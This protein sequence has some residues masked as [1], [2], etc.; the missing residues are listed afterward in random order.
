[1]NRFHLAGALLALAPLAHSGAPEPAAHAAPAARSRAFTADLYVSPQGRDTWSGKLAAPNRAGNDGP[2]ASL[3]RARDE[4]RKWRAAGTLPAREVTV[5]VRAGTYALSRSFTLEAQDSGTA[6]APITYRAYPGESARLSGGPAVPAEAFQP[7]TD[8]DVLNRVDPTVRGKLLRADLRALGVTDLGSFPVRFT[9]TPAVPELFFNDRRM[10]LARWPSE[11]WATIA[12]II[13]TGSVPRTGDKNT[14]GGVFEYSGDRPERWR[15][16]AGVWLLGYWCFDWSAEA[17]RVKAVDRE[18]RQITLAAPHIYGVKQGNPSPRRYC[19]LNLLEE[20]DHPGEYY[21]DRAAGALYFLPP[22]AMKG[23]R[24]ALSTLNAPVV[25]FSEASH[26]TL[27]GFVIEATLSDGVRVTGGAGNRIQA[28]EVRNTR[29]LGVSVIGGTAHRVEACDVHDT[30]TGG[31]HLTGGDRK[32]LTPAGHEAVNNHVWEFSK[33]KLTYANGITLA[34]V[35]NR[36]AHNRIHDAPHQAIAIAG[37]DHVFEMNVIYNICTET[38]D[39]GAYYKG[40]NPSCRGNIVRHNFWH[41]IGS[42]MGHGN[43]AVYFDD[44][45][46]GDVV[47]GNVFFRCGDPGKGSFG[48]VFSHGGHDLLAENNIF[49]ECKRPLGS[50]PWNDKRWKE[51]LAGTGPDGWQGRLLKEVDIT[52]PPYTTRYPD[53]VGFMDPQPGQVRINRAT[54]NLMVMCAAVSSGN[55]QVKPEENLVT[56]ADPGFVNA[57]AGDFRLR[58][59]APVF[60]ALPGFKPIPFEKMGLYADELRP[61]LP[62]QKWTYAPPKPLDPLTKAGPASQ[63]KKGPVPVFRVARATAPVNV[64]GRVDPAE[65][66]GAAAES[67]MRLT[68][69]VMGNPAKRQSRAWLSY[70]DQHLFVVVENTV[71]PDTKLDGNQWGQHD[72]V[73]I[74][75]QVPREGK[76]TP[77]TVLR[78]YGNGR[79]EYG[80][81]PNGA[82]DP[83]TAD[84]G[85]IVYRAA[86][87][88]KGLWVAEFSIPLAMLDLDPAANPRARFSLAVRKPLDDLWLMWEPTRGHSY[89]VSQAGILEFVR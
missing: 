81:T 65:W 14:A 36:A 40:R 19:A 82:E 1:M 77:I 63:A 11:G 21:I 5:A 32:A 59:N 24:V 23:A 9:D 35:G 53:L 15:V 69:D 89:D 6:E 88:E 46:G 22:A 58:A 68:Q 28:C 60:R 10:T 80:T 8:A 57:A 25:A 31:I 47:V 3:E 64:D 41:N 43:A 66:N 72:A 2:F 49:I 79:V 76:P 61:K 86:S 84:P 48:T 13:E 29:G 7:V 42:P 39:C 12:R 73:E 20:L 51:A 30:G 78:G 70:T 17:I 54:R 50:A 62:A 44:G 55:W 56:A 52:Q 75:L 18:K 85:A 26:V 83:Q 67:A 4:I 27:R 74:S 33:H 71:H 45:D 34:G 37:N 16:D 87:P 38:D